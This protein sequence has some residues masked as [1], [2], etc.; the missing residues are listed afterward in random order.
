MIHCAIPYHNCQF[1]HFI[2]SSPCFWGFLGVLTQEGVVPHFV[3]HYF[4]HPSDQ[5]TICA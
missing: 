4:G 5:L 2:P 3:T 1:P